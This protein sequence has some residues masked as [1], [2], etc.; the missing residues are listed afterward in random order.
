[1]CIRKENQD[2]VSEVRASW[3]IN[4]PNTPQPRRPLEDT[5]FLCPNLLL[6]IKN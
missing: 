4:Q 3:K 2:S 5:Q 1:M 6:Y